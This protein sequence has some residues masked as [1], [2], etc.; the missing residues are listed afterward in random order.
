MDLSPI[1][2]ADGRQ[3]FTAGGAHAWRTCT[4][5]EWCVSLEWARRHDGTTGRYL[6]IWPASSVLMSPSAT[7]IGMWAI[8]STAVNG[9]LHF[10][11][12]DKAT[13]RPSA[14]LAKCVTETLPM[15]GRDQNDQRARA[16]L[17]DVVMRF[18]PDLIMMPP[19]PAHVRQALRPVV[20]TW[21]ATIKRGDKVVAEM[22]S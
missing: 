1:I 21:E 22:V 15:L 8:S 9:M 20:P 19:A 10:D 17:T 18:I 7:N 6:V 11:L 13:G 3:T 4:Y 16:S 12:S 14:H 5:G 2:G